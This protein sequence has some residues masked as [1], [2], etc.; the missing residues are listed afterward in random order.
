MSSINWYQIRA[1]K[2][3]QFQLSIVPTLSACFIL[4]WTH[5]DDAMIRLKMHAYKL[6]MGLEKM[7][8]VL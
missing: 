3:T 7:M 6:L 4:L 2:I 1:T 8:S 5:A